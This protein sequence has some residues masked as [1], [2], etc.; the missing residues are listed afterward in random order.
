M[1]QFL[2]PHHNKLQDE[3]GGDLNGRMKFLIKTL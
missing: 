1:N 3:W 2:S